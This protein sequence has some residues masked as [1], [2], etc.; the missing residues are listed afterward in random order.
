M[1]TK[2]FQTMW[3]KITAIAVAAVLILGAVFLTLGLTVWSGKTDGETLSCVGDV[4]TSGKHDREIEKTDS[5][6]VK[7]G[8]SDYKIVIPSD[9]LMQEDA[10]ASEISEK[11]LEAAEVELAIVSD[12]SLTYSADA[13]Y[14]SVGNTALKEQAGVTAET[15]LGTSGYCI[16]TVGNSVFLFGKTPDGTLYSASDFLSEILHFEYFVK[17]SYAL[18]RDVTEIPLMKYNITEVPDIEYRAAN[19][20]WILE[21]EDTQTNYRMKAYQ[22]LFI[23]VGL[24]PWHNSFGWVPNYT[25]HPKWVAD[26]GA[27]LCYTAHGDKAEYASMVKDAVETLKGLLA[28][29][30]ERNLVTVSPEDTTGMCSC[31]TC[32]AT[33]AEYGTHSAAVIMFCNEIN[34]EI[35][36]WFETDEGKPYARDLKIIFFAYLATA[37]APVEENS[38]TGDLT[39]INGLK[40]D[41]GVGVMAAPIYADFTKP[42]QDPFNINQYRD[43]KAWSTLTD[44]LYIWLYC[45][46]FYYYLAP[47]DNFNAMQETY[48]YVVENGAKYMF[49]LGEAERIGGTSTTWNVLK[50]WLGAKFCWN[51]N[52]NM[53]ELLD[54]F[55]AG[56]FGEA[57]APMRKW[58]DAQRL[59]IEYLK[60]YKNYGGTQS[61]YQNIIREDFWPKGMLLNF[62]GY[63][64]EAIKAIEPLKTVEPERYQV[65]YDNITRERVSLYYLLVTLYEYNTTEDQIA[66]YKQNFKEDTVRLGFTDLAENHRIEEIY[67]MW[68][69]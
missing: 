23:P 60:E 67:E 15:D 52:A 58:F 6:I 57:A 40:C 51:V 8:K 24:K 33:V 37:S 21:D 46:N 1:K 44:D 65:L 30:P 19:F 64:E 45:V 31:A 53:N 38:S 9:F 36:A 50:A 69:I 2:I 54:E 5:F 18:D 39:P 56:Y 42:L 49:D 13:K 4:E 22:E 3:F 7:D 20:G 28:M 29:Y 63:T 11:I 62:L 59:H 66:L 32:T 61:I 41:E 10:A 26:N 35:R 34:K 12:Q 16:K 17:G 25:S 14:I 48:K 68:G 27:Q 43:I 55:F 47:Y